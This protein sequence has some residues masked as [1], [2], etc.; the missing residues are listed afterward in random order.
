M[1]KEYMMSLFC[2][3]ML[4]REECEQRFVKKKNNNK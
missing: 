2:I 3:Q 4:A 1:E